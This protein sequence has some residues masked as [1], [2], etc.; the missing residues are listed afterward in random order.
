[1]GQ[2]TATI[3]LAL[4]GFGAPIKNGLLHMPGITAFHYLSKS[5]TDSRTVTIAATASR[6]AAESATAISVFSVCSAY[7]VAKV[8]LPAESATASALY[9]DLAGASTR[10]PSIGYF[11]SPEGTSRVRQKRQLR[12]RQNRQPNRKFWQKRQLPLM[13]ILSVLFVFS[14]LFVVQDP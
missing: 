7:S 13:S 12:V 11:Q 10:T 2:F 1:M 4:A 8:C 5:A 9:P 6:I 14:V 3:M